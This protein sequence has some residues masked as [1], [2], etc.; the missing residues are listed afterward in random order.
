M[1]AFSFV[2]M[3]C[4]NDKILV[5][6]GAAVTPPPPPP[7][8]VGPSPAPPLVA[9]APPV[10]VPKNIILLIGDGMGSEQLKAGSFYKTGSDNNLFIQSLPQKDFIKN[11]PLFTAITDSAAAASA[12]A[13]GVQSQNYAISYNRE[14]SQEVPTILEHYKSLGKMTG[15]VTTT[16]SAHATPA[17]FAA[18]EYTRNSYNA[19][20]NDYFTLTRPNVIFGGFK[21]SEEYTRVQAEAAGYVVAED[22]VE[23]SAVDDSELHVYGHFG[24]GGGHLKYINQGRDADTPGLLEM[25]QKALDLLEKD[26][27]GYF[28][29]I[30]G[31]R[32]DH[33]GHANNINN[34]VHEMIEF[35]DVV[36]YV[37]DRTST[38]NETIVVVTADHETGGL[39]VTSNGANNIPS[40]SW[41]TGGHTSQD[42]PMYM[43]GPNTEDYNIIDFNHD[44]FHYLIDKVN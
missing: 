11:A 17:A 33:A 9:P 32:I 19:I 12:I 30:E 5:T 23:L 22:K 34:L 8:V 3:N 20:S 29:V 18:H 37:H 31:G 16:R 40:A 7:P 14:T 4:T 24:D 39:T 15:I 1:I 2:L 41:T 25:T 35:D 13:T 10:L 36:K 42:I 38:D 6:E 43:W 26:D 28:L 21:N 44:I 27:D